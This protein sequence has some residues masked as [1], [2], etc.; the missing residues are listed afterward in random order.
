MHR[1]PVY[2]IVP[3][4][5]TVVRVPASG[6]FA[7]DIWWWIKIFLIYI[8]IEHTCLY[9]KFLLSSYIIFQPERI[10]C[11]NIFIIEVLFFHNLG[12]IQ[13]Y[14]ILIMKW[15]QNQSLVN[16]VFHLIKCFSFVG[17]NYSFSRQTK[18]KI[19]CFYENDNPFAKQIED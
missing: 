3:L 10:S 6:R 16:V 9:R 14:F 12:I 18:S 4:Q 13:F 7:S 11:M 8:T 2:V 1:F 17:L 19:L 15:H 5:C